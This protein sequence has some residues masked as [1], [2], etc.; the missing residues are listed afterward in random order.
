MHIKQPSSFQPVLTTIIVAKCRSS[1]PDA[2]D[3][4]S[5][6]DIGGLELVK[7]KANE[8]GSGVKAPGKDLAGLGDAL[9]G[10]VVDNDVA[11]ASVGVDKDGGGEDGVHG[12]VER[13]GGEG[14]DGQ[15]NETGGDDTVE[16]PVV[17]AMRRRG[18]GNLDGVVH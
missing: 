12:G 8:D 1:L 13:A 5:K 18:R 17:G 4:L 6:T 11:E 16:G 3:G 15:G 9:R 2:L 14:S 10:N 7:G